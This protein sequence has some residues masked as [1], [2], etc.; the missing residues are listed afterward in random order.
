MNRVLHIPIKN[1]EE[2]KFDIVTQLEAISPED[3]VFIMIDSIGNLA[4]KKEV[5]DARDSKSVADMTRA[6]QMKSLFRMTTPYLILNDIPLVAVNHTYETQEMF[7][8]QVVSGGTGIVYSSNTIWIIGRR[9]NKVGTEI[10]GYD[11]I[12]NIEKSRFV[13]EK[14]K[15]PISVSWEGGIQKYSGLLEVAMDGG[16]VTKPKIGWY[17]RPNID[18]DKNYR[19]KDTMNEEFW[20][21]VLETPEFKKYIKDRYKY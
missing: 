9:Q 17:T 13:R 14:S 3:K 8:K 6:K 10:K 18:V 19:E 16:F 20:D 4:S 15:I 5:D 2:L 1:V 7:S 12:I 21:P 11:F